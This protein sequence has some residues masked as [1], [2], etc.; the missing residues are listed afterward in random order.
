KENA[1]EFLKWW[2]SAKTQSDYGNEIENVLGVSGRV[3]TA[4]IEAL[5]NLAWASKDYKQLMGELKWVKAIPE[6]PGSYYTERNINN[7][8][9][10]VYNNNEDPRE[11]LQD[12]VKTINTEIRSKRE[13]FNLPTD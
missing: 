4:N 7:A 9:Y 13:E 11:T 8:F 1:W 10:T 6:I 2:M 3:A 5:S 12:I